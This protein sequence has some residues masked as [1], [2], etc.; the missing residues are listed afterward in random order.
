M[1]S[2]DKAFETQLNNIQKRTGKTL[3]DLYLDFGHFRAGLRIRR[4]FV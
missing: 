3:D 1:S 4:R 2:V